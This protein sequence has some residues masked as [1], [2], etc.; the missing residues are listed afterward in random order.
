MPSPTR[1]QPRD[2]IS[3]EL[4]EHLRYPEDLFKVQREVLQTYHVEEPITFYSGSERWEV[5]TDPSASGDDTL[6]PPYYLSVQMPGSTTRASATERADR[7][8]RFSLTSVYVP[9]E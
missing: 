4:L 3:D 8:I 5:P 7:R 2:D 6:Q 9:R 1:S